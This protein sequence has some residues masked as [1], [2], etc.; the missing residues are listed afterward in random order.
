VVI[1]G[2]LLAQSQESL[3]GTWKLNVAKSKYISGSPPKSST[4]KWEA[5]QDG[6]RQTVDV[7]PASGEPRH[8]EA[9]GKFDGKDNPIKG[10][11]PDADSVAYSK[12]DGHTYEAVYKKGGQIT[13]TSHMVVAP[14]GK[15]RVTTQ[16]GTNAKG[17]SV[18]SI[19]FFDKQ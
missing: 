18:H 13:L 8:Y 9:S 11:N 16:T 7:A 12:I 5:T 14:D 19:Q 6:V 17:E 1:G 15:S 4:V 10:N 3:L 2:T